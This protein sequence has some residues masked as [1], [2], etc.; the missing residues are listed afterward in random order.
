MKA[1]CS[2]GDVHPSRHDDQ[3]DLFQYSPFP[4]S[5]P[6]TGTCRLQVESDDDVATTVDAVLVVVVD[7]EEVVAVVGV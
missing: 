4:N 7:D 5:K 1:R 2:I 6:K 3:C